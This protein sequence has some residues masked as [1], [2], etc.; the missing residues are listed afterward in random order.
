[1]TELASD[2]NLS[3]RDRRR[4]IRYQGLGFEAVFD[5]AIYRIADIS[6][7]GL[8][9]VREHASALPSVDQ[10]DNVIFTIATTGR[11]RRTTFETF[12]YVVR[13]TDDDVA[14]R[15]YVGSRFLPRFLA[16]LD[17]RRT[18]EDA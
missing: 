12:G 13:K 10:M 5:D 16:A 3:S 2:A 1:M 6:S 17:R 8:R 9:I 7:L 18:P 11:H 15:Y 4:A 14:I